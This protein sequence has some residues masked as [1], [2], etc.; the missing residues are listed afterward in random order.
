LPGAIGA[1]QRWLGLESGI[2]TDAALAASP[3]NACA[4]TGI[5]ASEAPSRAPH[6]P[7]DPDRSFREISQD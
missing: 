4:S 1:W 3:I 6:R 2:Q 7:T 5:D